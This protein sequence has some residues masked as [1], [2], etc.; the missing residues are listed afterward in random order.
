MAK[1]LEDTPSTATRASWPSTRSA[2]SPARC[3]VS[4]AAFHAMN[5]ER[6]AA[7]PH[8]MLG[9]ATHDTKRGE[10]TRARLA[11]LSEVP[12][13]WAEAVRAGAG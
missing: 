2:A 13:A 12:E 4:P 6:L 11:V 3:G 10:D 5:A 8:A 9:T 1:A 7:W